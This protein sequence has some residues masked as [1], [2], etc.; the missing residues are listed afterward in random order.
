ML[1][2]QARAASE[3]AQAAQQA[4]YLKAAANGVMSKAST[5]SLPLQGTVGCLPSSAEAVFESERPS[6]HVQARL[7][8]CAALH[9]NQFLQRAVQ[10][11]TLVA[12]RTRSRP[13]PAAAE[14]DDDL[15][16]AIAAS[17]ADAGAPPTLTLS[18]LV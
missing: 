13:A 4:G 9:G 8:W 14:E 12:L 17:L 10:E 7:W 16:A 1:R 2:G 5:V 11:G 15:A 3:G 6:L 18:A